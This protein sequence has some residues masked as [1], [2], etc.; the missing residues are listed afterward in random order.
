LK[1]DQSEIDSPINSLSGEGDNS[2]ASHKDSKRNS[3]SNKESSN[4]NGGIKRLDDE[5]LSLAEV[6][7]VDLGNKSLD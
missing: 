1:A 5:Q 7:S 4:V 3:S 2:Q 6:E